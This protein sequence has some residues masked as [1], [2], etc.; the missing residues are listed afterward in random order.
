MVIRFLRLVTV[1]TRAVADDFDGF[2][3]LGFFHEAHQPEG[4]EQLG[5][6]VGEGA[7]ALGGDAIAGQGADRDGLCGC[8]DCKEASPEKR[9]R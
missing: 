3:F 5:G 2:V 6:D 4:V 8:D 9:W 1:R 7:G